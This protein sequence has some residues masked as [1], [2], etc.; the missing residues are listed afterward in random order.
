MEIINEN[1]QQFQRK[2]IYFRL[3]HKKGPKIELFLWLIVGNLEKRELFQIF[4]VPGFRIQHSKTACCRDL[5]NFNFFDF[6][7]GTVR[8]FLTN[9]KRRRKKTHTQSHH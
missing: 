2:K 7:R 3:W 1:F 8:P 9:F 6:E 4:P 5:L